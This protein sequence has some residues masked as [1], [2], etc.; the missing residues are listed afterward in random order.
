MRDDILFSPDCDDVGN[1]DVSPGMPGYL[2]FAKRWDLRPPLWSARPF[3]EQ[4]GEH[5]V[6]VTS[7]ER[8]RQG[9]IVSVT[10]ANE[11]HDFSA[12]DASLMMLL[13]SDKHPRLSVKHPTRVLTEQG[14]VRFRL[15][16]GFYQAPELYFGPEVYV[17]QLGR[18]SLRCPCTKLDENFICARC[19]ERHW[20]V[21]D[22]EPPPYVYQD[23]E[24]DRWLQEE[25]DR[26]LEPRVPGEEW[27]FGHLNRDKPTKC[28][29]PRKPTA[30]QLRWIRGETR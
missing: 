2:A 1:D 7:V 24:Y 21:P 10:V 8:G 15:H 17:L 27:Q 12:L 26:H 18:T 3:I 20:S 28:P 9:N 14:H 11:D 16:R 29:A 22:P 4:T 5:P 6:S 25:A 23:T 30:S 19:G 13:H